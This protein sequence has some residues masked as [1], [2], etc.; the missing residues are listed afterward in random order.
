[1]R[2]LKTLSFHASTTFNSRRDDEDLNRALESLQKGGA[3]LLDI[4][5]KLASTGAGA[6]AVY[7]FEY[8]ADKAL[9]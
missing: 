9:G 8:E 6:T 5:V 2:Y 3:Q 1:M 4:K 7:V